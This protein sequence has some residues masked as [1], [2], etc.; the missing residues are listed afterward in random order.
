MLRQVI[1]SDWIGASVLFTSCPSLLGAR[2]LGL[3]VLGQMI[4]LAQQIRDRA[5]HDVGARA[6]RVVATP[7]RIEHVGRRAQRMRGLQAQDRAGTRAGRGRQQRRR[8]EQPRGP[9]LR[10][11]TRDEGSPAHQPEPGGRTQRS[12]ANSGCH[13][14]H[15][16]GRIPKWDRRR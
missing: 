14:P 16:D 15:L 7:H 2:A 13:A 6:V 3:Q 8:A 10:G 5:L 11:D 9:P 1:A 12:P 4:D